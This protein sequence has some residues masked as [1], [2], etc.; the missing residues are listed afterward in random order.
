MSGMDTGAY[1]QHLQATRSPATVRTRCY[2]VERALR[3]LAADPATVTCEQLESWLAMHTDWSRQTRRVA[4]IGLRQ[5]CAWQQ[6]T[7]RRADNPA[8]HLDVPPQSTSR[9]H[10][11]PKAVLADAFAWAHGDDWWLLRVFATTGMRRAEVA[12]MQDGDQEGGWLRIVGKG[13]KV[14]RVPIPADVS[15]W[16]HGRS[17]MWPDSEGH[18]STPEQLSARV[19][20]ATRGYSPHSIRHRY[21]TDAYAAGHDVLAVQQLLG[22]SSLA[23]TQQ[24]LAIDDDEL[25]AAASAT[26]AA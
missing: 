13:G 15:G 6:Q 25:T 7:G 22:H 4:T 10:P 1:R 24:Y 20:L 12:A 8:E 16:M 3:E 19:R 18:P 14:R 5:F 11:I 17:V 21:A 26:W 2:W 23:T 9:P